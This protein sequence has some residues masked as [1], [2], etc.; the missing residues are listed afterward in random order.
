MQVNL[1]NIIVGCIYKH[2]K[3]NIEKFTEQLEELLG[4]LNQSKYDIYLLGDFNI[5]FLKYDQHQSTEKYLDMLYSYNIIPIITKPT[6]I[7]NHTKTLIDHIYTNTSI[8]HITAGIGLL[9]I[10]DHLPVFCIA[11]IAPK[12]NNEK[13]YCRDYKNFNKEIYLNDMRS[14]AWSSL[15][16]ENGDLNQSTINVLN[17]IKTLVNNHAPLKQ[18]SRSKRKQ[19]TKP[20]ITNGILKSI[21]TKQKMYHTHFHSNNI[22]KVIQYMKYSNK[23]NKI[24]QKSKISYYNTQF[25]KYKTNL[26]ATWKLIGTLIQR[27]TKGQIHPTKIIRN[28]KTY[29]TKQDIANQFNHHFINVGS[30]LVN[31]TITSNTNFNSHTINYIHNSPI[32]SF[33]MSRVSESQVYNLFLALNSNKASIDI[34]NNMIKNIA[35]IISPIFT[36]IFNESIETGIVPDILKI[37]RV[38]PIYKSAEITDPF[39][40]RSISILSPFSMVFEKLVYNQLNSFIEKIT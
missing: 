27:K 14:I 26:K 39:N 6:R 31:S 11:N 38:T 16:S 1:K 33:V 17:T 10:S 40:Y 22:N 24:K 20:W 5:D 23:L 8:L 28:N 34:P 29:V 36:Y 19:F 30:T 18:V 35:P 25:T 37:S 3:A 7:T 9:D 2:P 12:Q 32:S 13:M 4:Q 21:K 15:L